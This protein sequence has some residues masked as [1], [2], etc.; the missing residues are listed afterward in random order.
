[1]ILA[2]SFIHFCVRIQTE[3]AE[4][5]GK[6]RFVQKDAPKQNWLHRVLFY[7]LVHVSDVFLCQTHFQCQWVTSMRFALTV[8]NSAH[9]GFTSQHFILY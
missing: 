3:L 1:M 4:I 2:L 9:A 6:Y 7:I 8:W 5:E